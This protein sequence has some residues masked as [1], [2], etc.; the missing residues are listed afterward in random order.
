MR[1][2]SYLIRTHSTSSS[3]PSLPS[4]PNSWCFFSLDLN[5]HPSSLFTLPNYELV[6]AAFASRVEVLEID[7]VHVRVFAHIRV[8][9]RRE[10]ASTYKSWI[11]T[12]IYKQNAIEL[13]FVWEI[14]PPKQ[15]HVCVCACLHTNHNKIYDCLH[16]VCLYTVYG[17]TLKCT[18]QPRDD[19]L[20]WPEKYCA[21][22]SKHA[23]ELYSCERA[24][25]CMFAFEGARAPKWICSARQMGCR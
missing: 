14:G 20:N 8:W 21:R 1:G 7:C 24:C 2:I 12:K 10:C 3:L 9:M 19:G 18:K 15:H 4:L 13:K 5:I 16:C 11:N 25:A 6:R 17:N 23:F 22:S